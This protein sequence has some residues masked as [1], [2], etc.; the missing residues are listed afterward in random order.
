MCEIS[1]PSLP[2]A[3]TSSPVLV[4]FLLLLTLYHRLDRLPRKEVVVQG[5]GLA[6]VMGQQSP[7]AA[8]R[9][10]WGERQ[11]TRRCVSSVLSVF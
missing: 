6:L 4:Q 3:M 1:R 10:T 2:E 9:V 5:Q 11:G 7:E 8:L